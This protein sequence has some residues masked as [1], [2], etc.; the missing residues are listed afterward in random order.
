DRTTFVMQVFGFGLR[1]ACVE[2]H[3]P[4]RRGV[5]STLV[6][7]AWKKLRSY[8]QRQQLSDV[9][10]FPPSGQAYF[11]EH[12]SGRQFLDMIFRP[13]LWEVIHDI[14]IHELDGSDH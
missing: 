9:F 3:F 8:L 11:L 2:F 14:K 7:Q 4:F 12:G 10:D 5:Y 13:T 1:A 6:L